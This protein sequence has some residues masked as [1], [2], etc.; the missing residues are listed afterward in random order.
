MFSDIVLPGNN[1]KE[2]IDIAAKLGIGKLY[3]LYE[4]D[5]YNEEKIRKRLDLAG[6]EKI[7]VQMGI[8]IKLKNLNRASNM[9]KFLAAKSS[10]DDRGAIESKKI[11]LIYGLEDTGKRD[12]MHQR[13][14]GLNHILCELACKNN[15]S[16]GFSYSSIIGTKKFMSPIMGKMMQNIRL[17]RKYKVKTIIASF[18]ENPFELRHPHDIASVFR[19]MGMDSGQIKDSFS[20]RL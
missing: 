4:F 12:Y 15:V 5:G 1:E 17:C 19:V 16:I 9:P 18:A 6:N 2:F 7:S 10:A 3:F 20:Y 13:S 8:I 11:K 14:S